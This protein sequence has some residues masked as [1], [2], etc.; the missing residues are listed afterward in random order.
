MA[1]MECRHDVLAVVLV[2][3]AL[4]H[5]QAVAQEPSQ[6]LARRRWFL[7]VITAG[8]E[9]VRYRCRASNNKSVDVKEAQKPDERL[10][11]QSLDHVEVR[12][13][14]RPLEHCHA[15]PHDWLEA[16]YCR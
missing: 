6:E 2:L 15:M 1:K 5:Q 7:V 9:D 3:I 10:A 13:P 12:L 16:A 11:G 4:S 14:W 8:D